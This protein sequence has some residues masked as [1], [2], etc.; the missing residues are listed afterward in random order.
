M[1]NIIPERALPKGKTNPLC[2]STFISADHRRYHLLGTIIML[3]R[4][5]YPYSLNTI[6]PS[7]ILPNIISMSFVQIVMKYIPSRE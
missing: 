5:R 2:D 7:A 1:D 6:R 3:Y 4:R